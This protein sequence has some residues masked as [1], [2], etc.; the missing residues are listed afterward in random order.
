MVRR[1]PKRRRKNVP[2]PEPARPKFEPKT[3]IM[4][5]RAGAA[6]LV[7]QLKQMRE[8]VRK[9][10]RFEWDRSPIGKLLET[11]TRNT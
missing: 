11:M 9:D 1:P 10:M 4:F 6:E 5:S 2:E 8:D 3:L 7:E